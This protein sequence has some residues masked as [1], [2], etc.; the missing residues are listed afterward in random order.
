MPKGRS[1]IDDL[2]E[3]SLAVFSNCLGM[4]TLGFEKEILKLMKKIKRRREVK[5]REYGKGRKVLIASKFER[6]FKK[7]ENSIKY[8]VNISKRGGRG[9]ERRAVV[10]V[11]Q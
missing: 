5:I 4:S 9:K 2:S 8:D 1:K 11:C 7:L 3:S 6:G 10:S